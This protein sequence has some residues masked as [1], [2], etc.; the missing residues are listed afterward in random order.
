[1]EWGWSQNNWLE[2]L[3]VVLVWFHVVT[4]I[5]RILCGPWEAGGPSFTADKTLAC[6]RC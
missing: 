6:G 5:M 3:P 1:M 2:W 4:E